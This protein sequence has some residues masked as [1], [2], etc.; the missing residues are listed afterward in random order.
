MGKSGLRIMI[1][2]IFTAYILTAVLLL[3]LAFGLYQFHLSEGQVGLGVNAIYVITCF[4]G[5]IIAGKSAKVRRFLWGFASG[6]VYF[7]ILLAVSFLINKEIGSDMQ[8]LLL[9]FA[10]C[11]GGGTLGGMIS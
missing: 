5:G 11:A 2:T 9:I 8:E 4:I 10:M 6:T 3:V 1:R 7:L